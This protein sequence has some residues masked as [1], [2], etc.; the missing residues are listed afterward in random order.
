MERRLV[1]QPLWLSFRS[2]PVAQRMAGRGRRTLG[3][4]ARPPVPVGQGVSQD[5]AHLLPPD[6]KPFWT[7]GRAPAQATLTGMKPLSG[8][9]TWCSEALLPRV[10]VGLPLA[11][12]A[13]LLLH[14]LLL[15]LL[16]KLLLL[17]LLLLLENVLLNLR[18]PQAPVLVLVLLL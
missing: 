17:C 10:E 1:G 14:L 12:V 15:K 7:R 6:C 18:L 5:C 11:L 16:M 3:P 9:L 2:V 4:R 8:I 13:L